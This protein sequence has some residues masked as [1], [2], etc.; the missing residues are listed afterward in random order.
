MS[1]SVTLY[2][3]RKTKDCLLER[4]VKSSAVGKLLKISA[5]E[6]GANG[7]EIISECLWG[8][9][10]PKSDEKPESA[11]YSKDEERVFRRLHQSVAI[12]PTGKESINVGVLRRQGSGYVVRK[13][14]V[15]QIS[16]PCTNQEFLTALNRALTEF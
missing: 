12:F 2:Q 10:P 9:P 16:L 4:Y 3:N 15:V 13:E 5:A 8:K 14:D 6:M 11:T 1:N 7:L